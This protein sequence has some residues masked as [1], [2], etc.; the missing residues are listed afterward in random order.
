M[1]DTGTDASAS[2][3][4]LPSRL[5]HKQLT[6]VAPK[7]S[8]RQRV[9]AIWQYRELLVGM[10]GKELRVQ[11]KDSALGFVWS[12]VNPTISLLVYFFVFQIILKNG[13][14]HFAIFL[15]SGMLVWNFFS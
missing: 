5:A 15:M 14:P 7:I 13:I 6:V 2:V 12:L 11:Y 3:G 4:P 9:R 8:L 10:S 1:S